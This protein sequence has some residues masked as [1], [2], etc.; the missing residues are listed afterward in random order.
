MAAPVLLI[1]ADLACVSAV[2]GA[3]SRAGAELRT[4]LGTSAIEERLEGEAPALVIIDLSTPGLKIGELM[5]ELRSRL[6]Q[7][8]VIAFGP[9]VHTGLLAAARQ[10]G[11][12]LVVSRGEL[13]ARIDRLLNEFGTDT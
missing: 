2:T 8:K 1:T 9:H 4:A 6:P 3:A 10:A 12:D 7:A 5:P 11:C 13:H